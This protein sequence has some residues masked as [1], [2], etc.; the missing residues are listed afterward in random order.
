MVDTDVDRVRKARATCRRSITKLVSRVEELLKDG[1]EGV[2]TGSIGKLKYFQTE[3]SAKLSE[4]KEADNIILH[5]LT[6]KEVSEED[7]DKEL[8]NGNE[9][10]EKI[11]SA[12][13]L[14]EDA[15]DK[16]EVGKQLL[17]KQW[18]ESRA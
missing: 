1:I 6:E 15:L 17:I 14:I 11:A 13:Y 2:D 18:S 7:I 12:L 16:L 4:L 5:D 10:R 3:L 8:D 9:Y